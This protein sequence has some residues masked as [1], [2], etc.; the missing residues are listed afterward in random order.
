MNMMPS[1]DLAEQETPKVASPVAV[2]SEADDDEDE[3][4]SISDAE[5]PVSA[6]LP[7]ILAKVYSTFL[8][9]KCTNLVI[10]FAGTLD[11]LSVQCPRGGTGAITRATN[12][13]E[14]PRVCRR[15]GRCPGQGRHPESGARPA[16]AS[17]RNRHCPVMQPGHFAP[18][19][20]PRAPTQLPQSCF[21]SQRRNSTD[22]FNS[23]QETQDGTTQSQKRG[24]ANLYSLLFDDFNFS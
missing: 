23:Q 3:S 17:G 22:G 14:H 11:A 19:R 15:R 20:E 13:R 6:N 8:L 21:Q 1:Q 18:G 2:D 4:C 5:T 16:D 24:Q 12:C 7:T 10:P 9:N